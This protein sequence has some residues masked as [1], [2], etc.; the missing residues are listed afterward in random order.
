[1]CLHGAAQL[2][3]YDAERTDQAGRIKAAQY[4]ECRRRTKCAAG[5]GSEK[6]KGTGTATPK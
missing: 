6:L 2:G 3:V 5:P 1:M 4:R